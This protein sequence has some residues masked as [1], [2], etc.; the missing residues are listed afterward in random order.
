[1]PKVMCYVQNS[2]LVQNSIFP[3]ERQIL[4]AHSDKFLKFE[5]NE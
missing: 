5:E 4:P 2:K 1:M 3:N